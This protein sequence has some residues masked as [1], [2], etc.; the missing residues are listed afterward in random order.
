M[1]NNLET[2]K[3]FAAVL[4][5]GIVAMLGGFAAGKLVD[6]H[7]P[8]Q[9]AVPVEAMEGSAGG[10]G[11]AAAEVPEPIMH[12][13]A[14]A[15]VAKGEKLSKACA[16]CHS[17]DNGGPNKVGPNLWGVLGGPKAHSK[18]FSYSTGMTNA[19]GT[20][21]YDELNHFLWSPKKYVK[22]TKMSFAGL[23]KAEDRA[24]LIAWLRTQGSSLGMPSE[25]DIAKEA[26]ALAP[27][28]AAE[29][30]QAEAEGEKKAEAEKADVA[31]AE[32]D[33]AGE[34]KAESAPAAPAAAH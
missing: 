9:D 33:K 25:T 1:S 17:F 31:K 14:A 2:N 8:E 15:D 12:L 22:G 32:G 21:G 13:I 10:G 19:G 4:T 20:W 11:S 18:E 6:P 5:A 24:A 28:P 29:P 27:P 34:A 26:A 23:K 7:A 3:I 16:A 30:A